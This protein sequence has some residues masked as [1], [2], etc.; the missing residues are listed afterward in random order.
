MEPG[1][2]PTYNVQRR[3]KTSYSIYN[4]GVSENKITGVPVE[5]HS[6]S[7]LY[8]VPQMVHKL[9]QNQLVFQYMPYNQ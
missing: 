3:L 1:A 8:V 4:T 2:L 7:M 9:L 5:D 6:W